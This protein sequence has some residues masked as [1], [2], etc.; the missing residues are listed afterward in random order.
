MKPEK[1]QRSRADTIK[2]WANF[3]NDASGGYG[4]QSID[5]LADLDEEQAESWTSKIKTVFKYV[6]GVIILVVVLL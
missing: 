3:A 2:H 6:A 5:D 4:G 1:E